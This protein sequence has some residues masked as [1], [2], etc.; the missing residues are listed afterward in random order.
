MELLVIVALLVALD[1]LALKYGYDS[2][3]LTQSNRDKL[4]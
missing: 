3:G 1:I 2:R 4:D